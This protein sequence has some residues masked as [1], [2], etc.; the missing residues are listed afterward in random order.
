MLMW[1]IVAG[2]VLLVVAVIIFIFSIQRGKS[3]LLELIKKSPIGEVQ[4]I[5][6]STLRGVRIDWIRIIGIGS[7]V[8]L[9]ITGLIMIGGGAVFMLSGDSTGIMINNIIPFI[10]IGV[11]GVIAGIGIA[12]KK[13]NKEIEECRKDPNCSI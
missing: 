5:V 7:S 1:I 13:T 3:P 12:V 4:E 2:V 8:I 11:L 6:T 9:G 10:G